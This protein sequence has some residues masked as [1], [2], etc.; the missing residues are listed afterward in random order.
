MSR[1]IAIRLDKL[2]NQIEQFQKERNEAFLAMDEVK[3]RALMLRHG[4]K[5]PVEPLVFWGAVHKAITAETALPLEF[6]KKSK[7]WLDAQ[8]F[9]SWDDGELT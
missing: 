2:K 8:G 9:K 4:E 7:A 1:D 3:I 6:R 5:M